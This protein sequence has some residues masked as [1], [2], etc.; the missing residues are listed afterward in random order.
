M[1]A[2]LCIVGLR[3]VFG[4]H[5]AESTRT[6]SGIIWALGLAV[7]VGVLKGHYVLSRTARRNIKRIRGLVDPRIWQVF[8][9]TFLIL[10]LC[11][12]GLG[13]GLRALAARD[14]LGGYLGVGGLYVG[15]GLGLA[16]ASLA[17]FMKRAP[18]MPTRIDDLPTATKE[19]RGVML[20]NL[21]SPAAPST[22][23]VRRFLRQFLWDRRVVEVNRALW[24]FVL[25][26]VILPFRSSGSAALYRKVWTPEGSPL[27]VN[28]QALLKAM[29]TSLG[30]NQPIVLGMR[31]G[32]PSMAAALTQ[33]R[34]EGCSSVLVLPLFPQYSNT[35]TGSIMAEMARLAGREREQMRY[36][37]T[38]P[39][40]DSEAYVEAL[41]QVAEAHPTGEFT[42]ISFHGIPEAYVKAGDPYMDQCARTAWLLA[43]RLGLARDQWEMVFQSQFGD[44]PWLQPY[45]DEYVRSLVGKIKNLRIIAPSFAADCLETLEEIGVSLR[46][47]FLARG[48][49][50]LIVVPALNAHPAWVAALTQTLQA[51][52]K[53]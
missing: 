12:M 33:L 53:A 1:G 28:G 44:E 32:E 10:I 14:Y 25:N 37:F 20:V 3:F 31:Y 21:G 47:E 22:T 45:L 50:E 48:G 49:Q 34:S 40:Y 46:E 15:I 4:W 6:T 24:A 35:T 2:G 38:A 17:Y 42:V 41:A 11:M 43:E 13:R 26:V 7:L 52:E 23:A 27:V 30:P 51:E 8:T 39:C 19:K 36:A 18:A 16:V 5:D 29:R 9:G